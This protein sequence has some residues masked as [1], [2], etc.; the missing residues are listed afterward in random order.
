M[1]SLMSSM[2]P[3]ML[4][5]SSS[6]A[7]KFS[8]LRLR[9]LSYS[10]RY[11]LLNDKPIVAT[12]LPIR[13]CTTTSRKTT[14]SPD[15]WYSLRNKLVDNNHR[16]DFDDKRYETLWSWNVITGLLV[17]L[18][19]MEDNEEDPL[20]KIIKNGLRCMHLEEYEK[21]ELILHSGLQMAQDL[22]HESAEIYIYDVLANNYFMKGDYKRA[23]P[24]FAVV[25]NRLLAKGMP[26]ND[27]SLVEISIKLSHIYSN[28]SDFDKSQMGFDFSLSEQYQRVKSFVAK[29]VDELVSEEINSLALLGM[30]YDYYAKHLSSIGNFD[31][32][33]DTYK[34]SLD[35]CIKVNGRTHPQTLVLL[36][37]MSATYVHKKDFANAVICLKRAIEGAIE[38]DDENLAKY[39]LNIGS[40][41]LLQL[42][43]ELALKWCQRSLSTT[44]TSKNK[45]IEDKARK[46]LT[47]ATGL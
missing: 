47:E 46:C 19:L 41:Y 25:F 31:S 21:A 12:N 27:E 20:I 24:L 13:C 8:G 43:K 30:C 29:S 1:S 45:P 15:K 6:S 32:A 23:E 9:H 14:T 38:T 44:L 33:I 7:T 3:L 40:V 22:Q 37:D 42:N 18:G 2:L 4:S 10:L 28:L 34:K 16:Q 39:Y 17:W 26:P 35:I 36:N 5:S 11:L